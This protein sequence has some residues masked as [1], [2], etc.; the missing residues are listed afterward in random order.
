MMKSTYTKKIVLL[1]A[2]L[3]AFGACE[4]RIDLDYSKYEQPVLV[5]ND[6][7][8]VYQDVTSY[9]VKEKISSDAPTYEIVGS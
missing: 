4:E 2:V 6:G 3:L 7:S 1:I 5:D 8:I 9:P